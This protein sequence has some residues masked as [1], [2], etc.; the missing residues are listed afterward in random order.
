MTPSFYQTC[1]SLKQWTML[2]L[3]NLLKHLK[4]HWSS[5]VVKPLLKKCGVKHL[6]YVNKVTLIKVSENQ[7]GQDSK[8]ER[9]NT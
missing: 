2:R 8:M 7:R 9:F 6:I 1:F 5:A 3:F 4:R